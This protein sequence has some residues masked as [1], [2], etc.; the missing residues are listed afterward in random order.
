MVAFLLWLLA[1]VVVIWT[2]VALIKAIGDK[3]HSWPVGV[4]L[5]AVRVCLV[6]FIV[7]TPFSP[8]Y[9]EFPDQPFSVPV[10]MENGHIVKHPYGFFCCE[11][12]KGWAN[13]PLEETRVASSVT[14][15]TD[16][17]RQERSVMM[18]W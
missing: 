4:V 12:G 8:L 14:P 11:S 2:S 3:Y 6:L 9:Y 13:M 18:W 17:P 7:T 5:L 1:S 15:I 10:T 16:N